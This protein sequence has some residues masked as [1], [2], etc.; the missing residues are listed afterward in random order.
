MIIREPCNGE[1][2]RIHLD[3]H[4]I[5]KLVESLVILKLEEEKKKKKNDVKILMAQEEGNKA[6]PYL[7]AWWEIL[8][9][10]QG[11]VHRHDFAITI[12]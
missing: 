8:E 9:G 3:L 7:D 5:A 4:R 10:G 12:K 2:R 11:L 6:A 1:D